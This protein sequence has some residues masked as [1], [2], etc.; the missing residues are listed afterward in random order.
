MSFA[1]IW[2]AIQN[3]LASG[4]QVRNW[5]AAKGYLGDSFSVSSVSSEAVAVSSPKAASEQIVPKKE[6]EKIHA[7]WAGYCAGSVQR[8]ILRDMTRY[9]KYII[10]ILRHVDE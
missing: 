8:H 4:D 3:R 6:F 9:S 2:N 5:T 1:E 10:S 7:V